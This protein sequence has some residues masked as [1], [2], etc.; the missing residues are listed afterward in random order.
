MDGETSGGV[1]TKDAAYKSAR[2]DPI[3][4]GL[5]TAADSDAQLGNSAVW[6]SPDGSSDTTPSACLDA[7]DQKA[8]CLGT[9]LAFNI[10]STSWTCKLMAGEFRDGVSSSIQAVPQ[11]IGDN[12]WAKDCI[13]SWVVNGQCDKECGGGVQQETYSI[14]QPAMEDGAPCEAV[15]WTNRTQ[16]CNKQPCVGIDSATAG[17][18]TARKQANGTDNNI[19][20]APQKSLGPQGSYVA[21]SSKCCQLASVT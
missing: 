18:A 5:L 17:N 20:N 4:F 12:R 2:G 15:A 9:W 7:C 19:I 6:T 8:A 1:T 16:A 11:R 14:I 10:T 13:G 21:D 3:I